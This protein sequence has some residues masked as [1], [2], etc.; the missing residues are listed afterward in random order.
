M[1]HG[2]SLRLTRLSIVS[3]GG[4]REREKDRG[5]LVGASE[6]VKRHV[7]GDGRRSFALLPGKS[8]VHSLEDPG[9]GVDA[10]CKE[11]IIRSCAK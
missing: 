2:D 1:G 8:V 6:V 4:R 9:Q 7:R 5:G 10:H 3:W 11:T